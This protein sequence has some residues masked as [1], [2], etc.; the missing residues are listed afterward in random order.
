MKK[1]SYTIS[2]YSLIGLIILLLIS[3]ICY[4][5]NEVDIVA[6]GNYK[7]VTLDSVISTHST[8][9]KALQSAE[10]YLRNHREVKSAFVEYPEKV[11][12]TIK[13]NDEPISLNRLTE[14]T[15][16][17]ITS[18]SALIYIPT[19]EDM[20]YVFLRYREVG[21]IWQETIKSMTNIKSPGLLK[22]NT[23][24]DYIVYW[25]FKNELELRSK[26][27]TFKTM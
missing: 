25:G 14:I 3:S 26:L 23:Q 22:P 16:D 20:R 8:Y 27:L 9:R 6:K 19:N 7:A 2:K 11:E 21:G 13:W 15:T 5:Q 24:Y 18:T 12:L 10:N 4:S 17:S 1:T